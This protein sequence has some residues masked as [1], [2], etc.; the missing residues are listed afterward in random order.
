MFTLDGTFKNIES[1]STGDELIGQDGK[2]SKVIQTHI[3]ANVDVLVIHSN[4]IN[5]TLKG[6]SVSVL[7]TETNSIERL[8]VNDVKNGIDPKKY[9]M[10]KKRMFS[11]DE[12]QTSE[13]Y[14][15]INYIK[16]RGRF[17][18]QDTLYVNLSP[19]PKVAEYFD[20]Y[21]QNTDN[22]I[23]LTL[24][25]NSN[26]YNV[27]SDDY[28]IYDTHHTEFDYSQY[29]E[30]CMKQHLAG[31]IDSVGAV[32]KL[33]GS[34]TFT[35]EYEEFMSTEIRLITSLLGIR[36]TVKTFK[37]E[38]IVNGNH[39][40]REYETITLHEVL[41]YVATV[42]YPNENESIIYPTQ[43]YMIDSIEIARVKKSISL[44][45]EDE[46]IR[47]ISVLGYVL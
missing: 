25:G 5:E 29:G 4:E 17:D 15:I 16:G 12:K 45:C 20:S 32:N 18:D 23:R 40:T 30:K 3:Q 33:D 44:V 1:C 39:Y 13:D 14:Y 19:H 47:P 36:Y 8:N 22:A 10:Y 42:L 34:V 43:S 31:Y 9:K 35:L 11:T 38:Y 7:N 6:T 41:K 26:I 37:T 28:D 2:I 27:L 46:N 21:I 24:V